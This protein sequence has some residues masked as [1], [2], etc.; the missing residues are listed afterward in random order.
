MLSVMPGDTSPSVPPEPA[1]RRPQRLTRFD[2]LAVLFVYVVPL[3][4]VT[5]FLF[6][7]GLGFIAGAL[8]VIEAAVATTVVVVRRRPSRPA[9]MAP[10]TARP[11]LVPL[12][13]LALLVAMVGVAVLASQ[14]G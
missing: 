11:W 1:G 2:A 8:L 10:A 3:G 5:V 4:A 12:V 6:A 9:G 7:V 14:G 13:M